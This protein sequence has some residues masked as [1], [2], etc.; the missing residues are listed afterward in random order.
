MAKIKECIFK[1]TSNVINL[2]DSGLPEGDSEKDEFRV[3]GFVK[4]ENGTVTLSYVEK[5]N[6]AAV[7]CDV[8]VSPEKVEVQRRGD[9]SCDMIFTVGKTHESVYKV[10][11][12][13]FDM[14]I[15]ALRI[16]SSIEKE[17]GSLSLLY[18]M[19][20]GGA[21]KRCRMKIAREDN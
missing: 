13:S 19:N 11:P 6:G 8:K 9:V 16:D 4:S 21:E 2:D 12:F 1:I 7:S 20:I 14:K 5:R 18:L 17:D 10:P 3:S 15:T